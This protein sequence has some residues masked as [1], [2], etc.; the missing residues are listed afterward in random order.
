[1][2]IFDDVL[3]QNESL[4]KNE[5]A[6]DYEFLPKE[7]PFRENEQHYFA[8]CIKPLFQKRSGR[9]LLIFGPPG[10]GKTAAVKHVLRELEE[11]TDEVHTIF[12]N[13]WQHNT[14]YKVLLEMCDLL[15][16]K[17]TQNKKTVDLYK[18]VAQIINKS[19]AIFVFDEIDKAE[20]LDF[21]YFVLE[22]IY[23]KSIFLITNY[24]SW[25]VELDERIKSRLV[26]ELQ[27]FRQ[28]NEKE[29][30]GIMKLRR[31]YAFAPNIWD[32][33]A[34]Q[35]VCK[36]TFGLKDI[37]S[38]LFLLKESSLLAEE[39]SSKKITSTYVGEAIK[40]LDDFTIK[41]SALLEQE[42]KLIY[43]LVRQN[44]GKKIG[45]LFKIYQL[46]G[47]TSSYKTFQRNISKLE[48]GK[49]IQ[50]KKITGMGG[51]TTIVEKKLSDF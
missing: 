10:I 8:T 25:L 23:N 15:G 42:Q 44:S 48:E 24:K 26:P 37:R 9:N 28:Y 7:I 45:D 1:M 4:I 2:G 39:K 47:G 32:E 51:N 11:K 40:K 13:C 20:D 50:T 34:F 27:E 46:K 35:K 30:T 14:T 29:T 21:L 41:N 36:K 16:Y 19:G 22:E 6:L 43:D 31:D 33:D 3:R 5:A 18:V 12:I 38:G 49:F 17:F